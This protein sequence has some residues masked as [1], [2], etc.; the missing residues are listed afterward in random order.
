MMEETGKNLKKIQLLAENNQK[1]E[2]LPRILEV[3]D[4][5]DKAS[6][7]LHVYLNELELVKK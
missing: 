3:Q 4:E 7:E 5:L 1:E 2:I 6:K